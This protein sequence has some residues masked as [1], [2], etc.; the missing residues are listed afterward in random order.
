MRCDEC[1]G[2]GACDPCS[3]YGCYPDSYPN[4]GDG[5]ECDVCDGAGICIGCLGQGEISEGVRAS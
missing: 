5:P 2:S 4:A 1:S 3:G